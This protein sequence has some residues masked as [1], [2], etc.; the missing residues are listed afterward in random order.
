[1]IPLAWEEV[2][3]LGLGAL[4]RTGNEGTADTIT[5]I[6]ADSR[7]VGP[8]DLFVALNTGVDYVAEA[9]A[10][11]AA[12][13]VP[14]DQEA[15][16]AG[17]ASLVRSKSEARVVA[18]VG[19]AG[20]TSTKDILGALCNAATSSVWAEASQN[21]EIGLPLT[22]CRLEPDT[23]VLVTEMGMRGLGQIAALC[24]I[25]RPEV[26][27]VTSIGPEH[28]ELVGTVERVAEANA[29]AIAALPPGG[30]AVV[31][32]D[33]VE[34]AP[35]LDRAD[36]EIRRFDRAT[37]VGSGPD[38]RFSLGDREVSL[39]LP[40]T[41]RHMAENTLAA[42]VAYDALGLPL[43]RAQ[44]GADAIEL[45]RWRGEALPLAGGGFV[46]NDAY[47]ANPTSMK[48]ALRD[49]VA[50]AGER[51]RVAILGEMAELGAESARYHDEIGSFLADLGIELVIA[52]GEGARPYLQQT[53]S[54]AGH[55]IPDAASFADAAGL[56][57]PGDAILVK[58]SR[59]VGLEGI[60]ASIEK[61]AR[62]W[63]ES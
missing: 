53:G 11:G 62:A 55:W 12:T 61:R 22:V 63:S 33:A 43:D 13:L 34:L 32:A 49:L 29:E 58:A 50:R 25:A 41:A 52:V 57:Q 15:A 9:A 23:A 45:S 4:D 2:A 38:W 37:V 47:N 7:A 24:A 6:K 30:I 16:L 46:V 3:A 28:L 1:V 17:L 56:L 36:I 27:I 44:A 51:R 39:T 19:S 60:P 54:P 21:N 18:V 26:A 10:R 42:L 8:G 59:A 31:P 20:K 14:D 48:A 40:F 5:G 35:Y